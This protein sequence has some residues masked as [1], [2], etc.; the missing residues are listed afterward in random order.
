MA[1]LVLLLLALAYSDIAYT[2]FMLA[3]HGVGIE[4]NPLIKWLVA[5]TQLTTGV[6]FGVAIPT[7]F[8][9]YFGLLFRPLLEII[10][11]ARLMLFFLQAN[12]LRLELVTLRYRQSPTIR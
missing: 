3:R 7:L 11:F 2:R 5:K 8:C 4:L 12:H 6:F 9:L 10:V 1:P